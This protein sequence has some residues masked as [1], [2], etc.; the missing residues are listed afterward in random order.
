MTKAG[1]PH[2]HTDTENTQHMVSMKVYFLA[3]IS[4]LVFSAEEKNRHRQLQ[5]RFLRL[6]LYFTELQHP[7]TERVHFRKIKKNGA[8]VL[9]I[10][11]NK[12]IKIDGI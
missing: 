5:A 9:S 11:H 8:I 7:S 12:P 1:E 3:G 2:F 4:L 6:N 10:I